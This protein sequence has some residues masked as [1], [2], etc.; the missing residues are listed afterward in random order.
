MMMMRMQNELRQ[1]SNCKLELEAHHFHLD[2]KHP[3]GLR[4]TCR[5]CRRT[6]RRLINIPQSKYQEILESQNNQC[7]ICGTDAKEFKKA[8]SVDHN[9]VTKKIR[10]LLCVNCNVGL[11]HFK[12]SMSNLHR[13]LLYIAKHND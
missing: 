1:C 12:D 6:S 10:G 9:H 7:A 8:L 11:G 3:T 5:L 4:N 2:R 13:A